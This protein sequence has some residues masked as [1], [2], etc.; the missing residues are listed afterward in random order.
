VTL[1]SLSNSVRACVFVLIFSCGY[2]AY[3]HDRSRVTPLARNMAWNDFV[4]QIEFQ[5]EGSAQDSIDKDL[6]IIQRF[7]RAHEGEQQVGV[8]DVEVFRAIDRARARLR[9]ADKDLESLRNELS[10]KESETHL[11]R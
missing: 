1:R 11:G 9:Q 4:H 10:W 8:Y 7:L 3:A 6:R 5:P 2:F